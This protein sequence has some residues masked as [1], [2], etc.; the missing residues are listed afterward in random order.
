[1]LLTPR[2][3]I[4]TNFL[5]RVGGYAQLPHTQTRLGL[6]APAMKLLVANTARGVLESLRSKQSRSKSAKTRTDNHVLYDI[7]LTD[8]KDEDTP[9]PEVEVGTTPA[10]LLRQV[11]HSGDF[12]GEESSPAGSM[13]QAS[14][15][16]HEDVLDGL[17]TDRPDTEDMTRPSSED[18]DSANDESSSDSSDDTEDEVD[19]TVVEDMRR[20]EESFKG[21]SQKYRLINRIGE[22]TCACMHTAF[23][24]Q[25]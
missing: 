1:M 8:P 20:L 21:I 7:V 13:G 12:D 19:E 25:Y 11:R 22:G 9:D 4:L 14:I 2:L 10:R 17:S 18:G 6:P 5:K 23:N 24:A 15:A 16:I 3:R